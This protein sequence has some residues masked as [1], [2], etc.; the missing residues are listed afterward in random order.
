MTIEIYINLYFTVDK[1]LAFDFLKEA[2][3]PIQIDTA[4]IDLL[5]Y[6]IPNY[7]D[8][9]KNQKRQTEVELILKSKAACLIEKIPQEDLLALAKKSRPEF[10]KRTRVCL[11]HENSFHLKH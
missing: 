4:T 1:E 7:L 5:H 3:S 11:C 10:N 8:H 2:L 9:L 6:F